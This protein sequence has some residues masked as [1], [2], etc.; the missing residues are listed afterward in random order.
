MLEYLYAMMIQEGKSIAWFVIQIEQVIRV[1]IAS[2][3]SMYH[4][5]VHKLDES[6]QLLLDNLGVNK[7]A[8][9]GSPVIRED[10]VAICRD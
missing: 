6:V 10:M 7:S 5:F 1:V 4:T 8:N 9:G 2:L 3:T